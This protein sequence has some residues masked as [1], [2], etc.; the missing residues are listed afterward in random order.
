MPRLSDILGQ[1]RAIQVLRRAI[2]ANRLAQAYLFSGPEG[3][4]KATTALALA[5]ALNCYDSPGEGC[6]TCPSCLK[7][8]QGLQC[9]L[10]RA[11]YIL[12]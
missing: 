4:G 12:T 10:A 2:S 8:K 1:E 5:T 11:N 6:L 7:I 3:V 9:E